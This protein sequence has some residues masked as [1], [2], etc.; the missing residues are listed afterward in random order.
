MIEAWQNHFHLPPYS[1]DLNPIELMGSKIKA[2]LRKVKAR[3]IEALIDAIRDAL[4][5]ITPDDA[6]AWF[7]LRGYGTVQCDTALSA[8]IRAQRG[9]I[10]RRAP[11]TP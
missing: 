10:A 9:V 8:S 1:P 2:F 7:Q 5:A 6:R 3:T 4:N 11:V